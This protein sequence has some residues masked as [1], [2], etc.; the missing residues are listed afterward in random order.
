MMA[1]HEHSEE[2]LELLDL[3]AEIGPEAWLIPEPGWNIPP[4]PPGAT[5]ERADVDTPIARSFP[6]RTCG[7][8][9]MIPEQNII[10][11]P[12]TSAVTAGAPPLYGTC[13]MSSPAALRKT[14]ISSRLPLALPL[15]AWP[16]G[17]P[18]KPIRLILPFPPGGPTDIAG[19]LHLSVK[20]VSTHKTRILEKLNLRSTADLVRYALEHKL[21]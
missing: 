7:I 19:R 15:S 1:A 14:S 18:T 11:W 5:G 16:Q 3:A 20:T 12:P 9:G 2:A 21:V 4:I 17:Y 6:L 10:T 8:A 13:V